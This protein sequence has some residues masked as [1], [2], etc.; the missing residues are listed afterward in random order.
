MWSGIYQSPIS[1]LFYFIPIHGGGGG[2]EGE[3]RGEGEGMGM[4]S[5]DTLVS[6]IWGKYRWIMEIAGQNVLFWR[7]PSNG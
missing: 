1:P 2:G 3:G 6:Q 4:H 7:V 5:V